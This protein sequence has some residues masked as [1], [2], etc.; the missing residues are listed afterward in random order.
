MKILAFDTSSSTLSVAVI[1]AELNVVLAKNTF[2]C[3]AQ[4]SE[5]LIPEIEKILLEADLNYCDL[6]L[7]ATTSGP[8]SFTGVRIG[9]TTARIIKIATGLPLI[10]VTT[11]EDSE[12]DSIGFSAYKKFNT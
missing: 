10:L 7:I 1:D 8:G 3:N 4:H 12:A 9:L 2:H 6:G 11:D 5:L